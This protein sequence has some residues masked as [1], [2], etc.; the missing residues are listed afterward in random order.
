MP[1]K[2]QTSGRRHER[3]K[4]DIS[5]RVIRDSVVNL[6]RA[7]DLS[8]TGMSVYAPAEYPLGEVVHTEFTLPNSRMKFEVAAVVKNRMG[9]RYGLEFQ[10][11]NSH[12]K[13]EISRVTGILALTQ[14]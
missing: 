13:A 11:L 5:V 8:C 2:S 12:Q 14:S 1:S 10:E 6:G 7:H 9:F 3:V 4:A